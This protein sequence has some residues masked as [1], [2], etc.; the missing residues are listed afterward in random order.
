M[1]INVTNRV[2]FHPTVGIT[3]GKQL[4]SSNTGYPEATS[5]ST[6]GGAQTNTTNSLTFEGVRFPAVT[7]PAWY[8]FEGNNLTFRNCWFQSAV[9]LTTTDDALFENCTLTGGVGIASCFGVTFRKCR[10][11]SGSDLVHITGDQPGRAQCTDIVFEE[12]LIHQPNPASGDH[13]D[14]MQVRGCDGLTLTRSSLDMGTWFQ[15]GGQDVLNAAF[16]PEG[17]NGGNANI[18]LTDCY[19]NGGGYAF[20]VRPCSGTFQVT[21]ARFGPDAFYGQ[22]TREDGGSGVTV[23][24]SGNVFDVS[25]NPITI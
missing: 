9:Q 7:G 5:F 8:T 15:I 12:T 16:F 19:L 22:V 21:G 17:G 2:A 24:Q 23:T 13:T 1:P 10:I 11:H 3:H 14:G 20:R 25:G 6:Y 4:T 18:I